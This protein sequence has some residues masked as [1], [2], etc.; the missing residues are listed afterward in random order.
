[1]NSA[2]LKDRRRLLALL[3]T[4]A[5]GSLLRGAKAGPLDQGIGGTGAAPPT[6]E[7]DRGIGGTGVI[8]TI[9]KFGS[10]IVNDLRISYPPDVAVLIDGRSASASDLRIGQVVRVDAAGATSTLSTRIIDVTCEVVGGI[11]RVGAKQII[12][13][14]QTV[15]TAGLGK[16][17]YHVGDTVA[18]S[19]LRRNDGVIVASLIEKRP[20]VES[21]VAGPVRLDNDGG[22]KIGDLRLTGLDPAL[23]GER[24]VVEGRRD[25]DD[26]AVIHAASETS[27]L[28]GIRTLSVESYVERRGDRLTLGSGLTVTNARH[29]DL[30]AGRSIR[31][32]LTTS[33]GVDGRLSVESLRSN[34]S[35]YG[36][37]PARPDTSRENRSVPGGN[38]APVPNGRIPMD[39]DNGNGPKGGQGT[40]GEGPGNAFGGSSPG[41]GFG[42]GGPGSGFGGGGPGGGFGGGGPGG[43]FGGGGPGGG[44]PG[45][46]R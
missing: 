11:E 1:M 27:L 21:R 31:S 3:V 30:P 17:H 34:E 32:V 25:G 18:V 14:G 38:S 43:G 44:G 13:L 10:I 7:A 36:G 2:L 4:T 9:R 39:F 6:G 45:G 33:V 15:I 12:V 35:G 41:S 40:P 26:L 20:G 28:P 37:T 46:R 24:V 16:P 8:G 23:V 19:G 42:G 22:L 29:L 5:L